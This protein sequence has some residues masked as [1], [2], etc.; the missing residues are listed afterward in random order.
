MAPKIKLYMFTGSAPSV[1]AQL[2]VEHKQLD[3]KRVH[4]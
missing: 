2:M 1:T 3:Y 4:L